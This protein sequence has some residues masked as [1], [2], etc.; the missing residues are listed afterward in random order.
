MK[1]YEKKKYEKI[2][3]CIEGHYV[4]DNKAGG[5]LCINWWHNPQGKTDFS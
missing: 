4:I 5:C 2:L 1:K 3:C